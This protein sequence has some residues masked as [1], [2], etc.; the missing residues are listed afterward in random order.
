ML[1][2]V[3]LNFLRETLNFA[4]KYGHLLVRAIMPRKVSLEGFLGYCNQRHKLF[5][6]GSPQLTPFYG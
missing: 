5:S 4:T 2:H 6:L 1:L 3:E